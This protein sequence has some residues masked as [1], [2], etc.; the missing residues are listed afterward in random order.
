MAG[1]FSI[2]GNL[3]DL[4]HLDVQFTSSGPSLLGEPIP[5]RQ[6]DRS[7]ESLVA[8]TKLRYLDISRMCTITDS[9]LR[10]LAA[11]PLRTLVMQSMGEGITRH[12]L[13]HLLACPSLRYLDMSGCQTPEVFKPSVHGYPYQRTRIGPLDLHGIHERRHDMEFKFD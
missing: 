6:N 12:G 8:L 9:G 11:M 2:L 5:L 7:L 13:Q 4:E 1:S 3:R 10:V